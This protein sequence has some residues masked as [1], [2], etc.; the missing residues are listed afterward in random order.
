[1]A[2]VSGAAGAQ[3]RTQAHRPL[4]T[5]KSE[6]VSIQAFD[7][8]ERC[9]V[10]C[11]S[12]EQRDSDAPLSGFPVEADSLLCPRYAKPAVGRRAERDQGVTQLPEPLSPGSR[13]RVQKC[14][15]RAGATVPCRY[16]V[17]TARESGSNV[18][19]IVGFGIQDGGRRGRRKCPDAGRRAWRRRAESNR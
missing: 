19:S 17:Y 3:T 10:R 13:S 18:G 1:M 6:D 8:G 7:D 15:T 12:L 5:A 2:G 9:D 11:F 16:R 4:R 14:R